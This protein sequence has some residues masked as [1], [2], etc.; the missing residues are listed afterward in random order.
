MYAQFG[1]KFPDDYWTLALCVGTYFM[2]SGIVTMLEYLVVKGSNFVIR[3]PKGDIFVGFEMRK[4][5]SHATL[6]MRQGS[7][8]AQYKVEIEKLFDFE[9]SLL[10]TPTLNMFNQNL[11]NFSSSKESKK[12]N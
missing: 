10:Q 3:D 12:T 7:R 1:L 4:G 8:K 2:L 11:G 9:G 6:S 5:H